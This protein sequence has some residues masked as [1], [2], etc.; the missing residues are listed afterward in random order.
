MKLRDSGHN[1]DLCRTQYEPLTRSRPNLTLPFGS[2][3]KTSNIRGCKKLDQI[4]SGL[5]ANNTCPG[6]CR[7]LHICEAD[8]KCLIGLGAWQ[9]AQALGFNHDAAFPPSTFHLA[10]AFAMEGLPSRSNREGTIEENI[11]PISLPRDREV[12]DNHQLALE[13]QSRTILTNAPPPNVSPSHHNPPLLHRSQ[14][15]HESNEARQNGDM[16]R[17]S[18]LVQH[19]NFGERRRN[20]PDTARVLHSQGVDGSGYC[21]RGGQSGERFYVPGKVNDCTQPVSILHQLILYQVFSTL[22]SEP[23]GEGARRS[24]VASRSNNYSHSSGSS[25][26]NVYTNIA[27]FIVLKVD[28]KFC[29]CL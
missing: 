3:P 2:N 16:G 4:R 10:L 22:W 29:V 14:I 5:G 6:K 19:R 8:R 11:T 1:H 15:Y 28:T 27:Y 13:S 24:P 25:D 20:V 23:R 21:I 26:A 17:Y 9:R 7:W 18:A 12:H